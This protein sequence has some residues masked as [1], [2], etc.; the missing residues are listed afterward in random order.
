MNG[1]KVQG[2]SQPF[3]FPD[4]S[5]AM[6]PGDDSLFAPAGNLIQCRCVQTITLRKRA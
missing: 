5:Q 1:Q 3:T 6:Y 4:M 2:L